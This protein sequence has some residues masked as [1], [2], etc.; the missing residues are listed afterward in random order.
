[1]THHTSQNPPSISQLLVT[2][3]YSKAGRE[4][5]LY[6]QS[7]MVAAQDALAK[8][9]GFDVSIT[10]YDRWMYVSVR[11]D[12][13]SV[14]FEPDR[15][16][17]LYAEDTPTPEQYQLAQQVAEKYWSNFQA[18]AN[19]IASPVRWDA[20]NNEV[21]MGFLDSREWTPIRTRWKMPHL[22]WYTRSA[23]GQSTYVPI[24]WDIVVDQVLANSQVA[25]MH[26]EALA[27]YAA[28][29]STGLSQTTV[30]SAEIARLNTTAL[31]VS[32]IQRLTSMFGCD[33]ISEMLTIGCR[34]EVV[35]STV[36]T[37]SA[38][39][40]E[41]GT[42]DDAVP[43]GLIE[44]FTGTKQRAFVRHVFANPTTT[45]KATIAAVW[46]HDSHS[47]SDDVHNI[48]KAVRPRLRQ[49][50]YLLDLSKRKTI[51]LKLLSD[52]NSVTNSVTNSVKVSHV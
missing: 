11:R 37:H 26:E 20:A 28:E 38:P 49:A 30:T 36:A 14:Y 50:G 25:G 1:M 8:C 46:G 17:S 9:E 10:G 47:T 19:G 18:V 43:L 13:D 4:L 22:D 42:P 21:G 35:A 27:Y 40:A 24:P 7:V 41:N 39:P 52:R 5:T 16:P 15:T 32:L 33:A 34:H 12:G 31:N 44:A 2:T 6:A 51:A 23:T 48:V 45:H 3:W 29:Y